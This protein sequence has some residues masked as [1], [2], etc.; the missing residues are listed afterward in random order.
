MDSKIEFM[1]Q[2]VDSDIEVIR[3]FWYPGIKPEIDQ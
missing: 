2:D 3:V 1:K